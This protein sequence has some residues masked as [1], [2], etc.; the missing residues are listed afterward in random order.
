MHRRYTGSYGDALA[1]GVTYATLVGGVPAAVLLHAAAPPLVRRLEPAPLLPGT[2]R[3]LAADLPV[4]SLSL[5]AVLVVALGWATVRLV[6][7]LRTSVRAVCGQPAGTGNPVRDLLT[8]LRLLATLA[9]VALGALV[10]ATAGGVAGAFVAWTAVLTVL[11]RLLTHPAPGRPSWTAA[12]RTAPFGAVLLMAAALGAD[13]YVRLTEQVHEDV[14][15]SA[16]VLV[17]VA[18]WV[19]VS[20]RLVLRTVSWSATA[21]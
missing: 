20:A 2:A 7:A 12:A 6:R 11:P 10:L 1:S 21:R 5:R 3:D 19:S 14:Y 18:V 17:G 4:T 8:D 15:R 13:A 16:G 9:A